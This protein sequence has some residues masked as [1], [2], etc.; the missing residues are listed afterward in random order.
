MYQ[1]GL[2]DLN[3]ITLPPYPDKDKKFFDVFQNYVIRSKR[4]D[5]LI[6]H[7]RDQGV[8]VL[9]SWPKPTHHHSG[10]NLSAFKLP[11]TERL[12]RTVVSL[13]MFPELPDEHVDIVI[14]KIHQFYS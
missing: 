2:E 13:P 11:V 3:D 6:Q 1:N 8:E 14:K 7:L 12:S 5:R 4:R 10:L 9:I